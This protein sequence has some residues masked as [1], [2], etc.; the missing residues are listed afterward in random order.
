MFDACQSL[1]LYIIF[2]IL[3]MHALFSLVNER[4]QTTVIGEKCK[5]YKM[6]V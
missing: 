5:F 1:P 6:S 2:M 4:F 3:I